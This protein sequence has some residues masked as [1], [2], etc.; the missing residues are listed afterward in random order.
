MA[1][2]FDPQRFRPDFPILDVKIH[3]KPL[4]YFD[5]AASTQRPRQVMEAMT[6]LY[7]EAYA[8]VHRGVH[9]L[10]DRATEH[11]E[12]ARSKVQ[13]FLGAKNSYEVIFTAG[14]TLALNTVARSW[15]DANLREGDEIL[16]LLSE[17]HSNIVP[18]QQAAARNGAT[19]RWVGLT[20]EGEIDWADYER[21]LQRKPKLVAFAAVSNV[22]GTLFPVEKIIAAAHAVGA[23]TVVD[24]AQAA[25]HEKIDVQKWDADFLAFSGHK[26]L[27]PTGIG[28]LYG[29]EQLLAEMPPFLG[30]GS[31]IDQVTL[32]GFT[33]GE[34]PAK[35]EAGTPPIAEAAG[36]GAAI[37]Y[38]QAI[39]MEQVAEHERRLAARLHAKLEEVGDVECFG[40]PV[41]RKAG[42]VCFNLKRIHAQDTAQLLDAKGVAVR[43]GHHCTMPLHQH[44]LKVPASCRA[45]LYLY[46]TENEV[47]RFAEALGQ[48]KKMLQR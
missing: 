34:L 40:P 6:R 38:L 37:D 24:A 3:G 46:N 7:E 29:K 18:W 13:T 25:P 32:E 14:T 44:F 41:E 10:G 15:G 22:L 5:N 45:S 1:A 28:V 27:G 48:V 8:N 35:F 4:I 23:V 11:Y 42:I 31:M 21:H 26:I 17:H 12:T 39:G 43:A 33:P 36:L 30:G 20:P 47:D 2:P 9:S 19:I 16:L